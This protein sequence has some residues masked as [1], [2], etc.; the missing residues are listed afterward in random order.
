VPYAKNMTGHSNHT[1]LVTVASSVPMVLLSKGM[2]VKEAQEGT[3]MQTSTVQIR[4]N[5]KGQLLLR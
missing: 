1:I 4:E 3:D 5:V 2:G